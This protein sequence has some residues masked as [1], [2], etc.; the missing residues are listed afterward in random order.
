MSSR[1]VDLIL[2]VP[3]L[4]MGQ[5]SMLISIC[6]HADSYKHNCCLSREVIAIESRMT[7]RQVTRIVPTLVKAGY[8]IFVSGRGKASSV[9]TVQ[10]DFIKSEIAKARVKTR[11]ISKN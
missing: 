9:Y 4:T 5:Q 6:R 11:Q 10:A 7:T 3:G 1:L 8:I 2:D